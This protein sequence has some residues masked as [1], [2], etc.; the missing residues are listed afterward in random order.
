MELKVGMK[1]KQTKHCPGEYTQTGDVLE[2]TSVNSREVYVRSNRGG[3]IINRQ[4]FK[5]GHFE[6]VS[7]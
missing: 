5:R 2:V 7:K 3:T 4:W 6:A 1:V